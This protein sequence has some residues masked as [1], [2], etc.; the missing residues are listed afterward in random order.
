MNDDNDNCVLFFVKYPTPGKV[1]TRLAQ[2]VGSDQAVELYKCFVEDVVTLL[3]RL[4]IHFKFYFYPADARKRFMSW[5]GQKYDYVPQ[6]GTDLGKR[7]QSAF[8]HAF[9]EGFRRAVIIGSDI[10]DLPEDFLRQAFWEMDTHDVVLGPANDGGYYLVG[11]TRKGF[12]PEAFEN[13][14]WSSDSVFEQTVSILKQNRRRVCLL[15]QWYDVDTL[16]DF[17]SLLSRNKNTAFN[18]SRTFCYLTTKKSWSST[19]V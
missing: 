3:D 1:K 9:E 2:E 17:A 8:S 16:A 15:P 10:P 7:M 14:A 13:V 18:K 4:N 12:L 6:V 5:L 11:F 19:N